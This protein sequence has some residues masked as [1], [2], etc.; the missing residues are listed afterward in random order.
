MCVNHPNFLTFKELSGHSCL[1]DLK[2]SH[3]F[4]VNSR[5]TETTACLAFYLVIRL[6]EN[7]YK[8]AIS[9]IGN[10]TKTLKKYQ[11]F[12]REHRKRDYYFIDI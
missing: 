11:M 3:G 5:E 8:K 1:L 7:F 9:N 10:K 4:F 12:Q 6:W 2:I